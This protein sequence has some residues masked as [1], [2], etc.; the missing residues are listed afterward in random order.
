ML[1][2]PV[3]LKNNLGEVLAKAGL[4]QLRIAETEKYAHVTFFFNGGSDTQFEGE[5]RVLVPSPKVATYDLKPEMSVVEL[6]D[7]V[8][9]AIDAKKYDVVIMNIANPD[10]VGHTGIMKA[11]I[12]AVHETDVAV[13]RILEAVAKIDG[14]ALITADH[15]NCELMFDPATGQPHTAHTTNPV[16]LILVDAQRRFGALR[17]GGVLSNVAPTMLTILGLDCRRKPSEE[18]TVRA[19]SPF[20]RDDGV[21]KSP[22]HALRLCRRRRLAESPVEPLMIEHLFIVRHGQ[23]VQNVAGIAQGWNDSELSEAGREQVL[24]LAD[25]LARG[26]G[27]CALFVAARTRAFDG[28]GDREDD[29]VGDRDARRSSRDEL[30]R[31]GRTFFSR[32]PSRR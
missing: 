22:R 13:G 15:G 19:A 4:Q 23:T 28:A 5:D 30:R 1:Y 16:P 9:E 6:T 14:V 26:E 17:D 8:I 24:R 21:V 2:P 12:E 7:K 20:A 18:M 10:M 32:R 31:L 25:R 27:H 29:G 3:A 11:A